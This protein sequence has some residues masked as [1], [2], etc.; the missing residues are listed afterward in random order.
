M[1]DF[2]G[3]ALSKVPPDAKLTATFTSDSNGQ[4]VENS[5]MRN[6]V[7]GGWRVMLRVR[8]VDDKK[9][10]ELRGFLRYNNETISETW[11]YILEA[12]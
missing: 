12:E 5:T 7:T 8:R 3:P 10:T 11:S 2:E 9:P 1:V 6:D 4:I